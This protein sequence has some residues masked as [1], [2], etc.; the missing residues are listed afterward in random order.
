MTQTMRA[1][2]FHSD[3]GTYAVE[4]VPVPVAGPGQVLVRVAFCGIC[5]S[6]LSLVHGTIPA[7]LPVVT[8]G[9]EASGVIAELG[10]GVSGWAI[11]DRVVVAAGRSCGACGA[12]SRH[13]PRGCTSPR[14]MAFGYDGGWAEYTV[15]EASG[16]TLVPDD[17]PLDQA[18]ILADAVA[19]PFG[20]V[21]RTGEIGIGDAVGV[22]GVGGVGTHVVQLAKLV[23]AAPILAF[24]I[25]P[26]VR[27]RALEMGADHAVDPSEPGLVETVHRLTGGAMLDAAFDSAGLGVTF[28]QALESVR[29]GGRVIVVGMSDQAALLGTTLEFGASRK[30]VLGHF[31]YQNEDIGVLAKLVSM[32]R[33]DLSRSIS[34]IVSLEDVAV[35]IRALERHEGDPIRILVKP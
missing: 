7:Q 35:G 6:D 10:P 34:R 17:V 28:A 9:H 22:W 13:D 18:A 32:G 16:L 19:T 12:C 30:R 3:T 20:A 2:R 29:R 8:Q 25:N 14:I 5:H 24:D 1:Q 26:A 15:A 27:A 4:D 33:L 23:G 21:V 11:G 31:G